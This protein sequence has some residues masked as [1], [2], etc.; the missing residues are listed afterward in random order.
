MNAGGR[1]GKLCSIPSD[2]SVLQ[3][4]RFLSGPLERVCIYWLKKMRSRAAR[5]HAV[6]WGVHLGSLVGQIGSDS[7]AREDDNANRHATEHQG[8]A[9]EGCGLGAFGPVRLEGDL[10]HFA[11]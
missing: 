11:V 10:C 2:L 3:A 8:V 1:R 6:G 5:C 4:R 7:G 9:L